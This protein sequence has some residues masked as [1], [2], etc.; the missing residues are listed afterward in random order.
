MAEWD[1]YDPA[2]TAYK[3]LTNVYKW[4]GFNLDGMPYVDNSGP[5]PKLDATKLIEKPL[6]TNPP[7]TSGYY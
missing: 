3:L 5:E 4:F 7:E 6:P 1:T 2:Q